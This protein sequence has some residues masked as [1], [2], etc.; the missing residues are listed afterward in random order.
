MMADKESWFGSPTNKISANLAQ[1]HHQHKGEE[2]SEHCRA[3]A[4]AMIVMN[5]YASSKE[6]DNTFV[7]SHIH[8]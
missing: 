3:D 1:P 7:T 5:A 4:E 8:R 6:P 2:N